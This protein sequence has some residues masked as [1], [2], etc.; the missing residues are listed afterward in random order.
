MNDRESMEH[1]CVFGQRP[2]TLNKQ[3]AT[4]IQL[5]GVEDGWRTQPCVGFQFNSKYT[6]FLTIVFV[7]NSP[8]SQ[9][10]FAVDANLKKTAMLEFYKRICIKSLKIKWDLCQQNEQECT[11][12]LQ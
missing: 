9:L 11:K 4:F 3:V 2:H 10:A 12:K 6:C 5:D 1:C 8:V 7:K